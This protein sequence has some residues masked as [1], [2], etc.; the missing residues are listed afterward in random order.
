[1]LKTRDLREQAWSGMH[2]S[3]RIR[4]LIM[5][6]SEPGGLDI[7]IPFI[8]VAWIAN[9]PLQTRL[10]NVPSAL[11]YVTSG[12]GCGGCVAVRLLWR[13]HHSPMAS[14]PSGGVSSA[15]VFCILVTNGRSDT[16][17]SRLSL[18][19]RYK[20]VAGNGRMFVIWQMLR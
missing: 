7:R 12:T 11:L 20:P 6:Y 17:H 10:G 16:A 15:P 3:R 8:S 13:L 18:S 1:M 5:L 14:W 19:L 2:Y 9:T 4:I